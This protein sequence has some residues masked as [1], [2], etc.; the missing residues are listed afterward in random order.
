MPF[1]KRM[2][3]KKQDLTYSII[4]DIPKKEQISVDEFVKG[5]QECLS[6][7][8]E[9]NNVIAGG[10]DTSIKVISYIESLE[11]GS[12]EFKLKDEV[13]SK[14]NDDAIE[15]LSASLVTV[16]TGDLTSFI[17]IVLKKSRDAIIKIQGKS[18][19]N[20]EKKKL[21]EEAITKELNDSGI[22]NELKGYYLDKTRLSKAIKHFSKGVQKTGDNVF[23]KPSKTE[24]KIKINSSMANEEEA[25]MPIIEDEEKD[26]KNTSEIT[27]I[28]QLLTPTSKK[29][30]LWEFEENEGKIRCKMEDKE[31][32]NKYIL[33][34]IKLG[35]NEKLKIKMKIETFLEKKSKKIKKE[36]TIL[37]V[38]EVFEEK[39][40][41]NYNN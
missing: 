9:I 14:K 25:L 24:R 11:A 7:L 6:A 39:N 21:I 5:M 1:C 30:Y 20:K 22:N 23:Y 33:N 8:E 38:I 36:Y 29:D 3:Q 26:L 18:I 35:G 32:F 34:Q 40:L 13:K 2:T 10:I 4:F 37:E 16:A 28:Y 15:A 12:I 19:E 31:F 41:F 17:P 27:D